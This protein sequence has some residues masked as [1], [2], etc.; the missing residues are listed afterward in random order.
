MIVKEGILYNPNTPLRYA[1]IEEKLIRAE[2]DEEVRKKIKLIMKYDMEKYDLKNST[3][4]L[5]GLA[6]LGNTCYMN[7]SLQCL[8]NINRLRSY[9]IK[10]EYLKHLNIT[11]GNKNGS[12]GSITCA[13]AEI[14]KRLW[15]SSEKTR[16]IDP[17]TFK[18]AF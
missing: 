10:S 1:P 2:T 11:L 14:I 7:A 15:F 6:N 18:K 16:Y 12:Y 9:F 8:S 4:G 17:R 13:L 3:N 5:V